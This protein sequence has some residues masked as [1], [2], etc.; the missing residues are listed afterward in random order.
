MLAVVL[1]ACSADTDQADALVS[2]LWYP[3]IAGQTDAVILACVPGRVLLDTASPLARLML[4]ATAAVETVPTDSDRVRARHRP[5]IDTN[6]LIDAIVIA[7]FA[8]RHAPPIHAQFPGTLRIASAWDRADMLSSVQRRIAGIAC[9]TLTGCSG[10][11]ALA[12][13]GDSRCA[14]AGVVAGPTHAL[15]NAAPTHALDK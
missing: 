8:P 2:T 6:P 13:E 7:V 5:S 4:V 3:A 12:E 11:S 15:D 14:S 9:C 1:G 10:C